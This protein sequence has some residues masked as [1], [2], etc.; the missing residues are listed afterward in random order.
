MGK[1]AERKKTAKETSSA[2]KTTKWKN[3]NVR[4]HVGRYSDENKV[5]DSVSEL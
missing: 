4:T 2:D 1:K 3:K 5:N